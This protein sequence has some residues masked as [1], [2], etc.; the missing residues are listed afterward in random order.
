MANSRTAAC[1]E[2]P[3]SVHTKRFL[4]TATA[5]PGNAEQIAKSLIMGRGRIRDYGPAAKFDHQLVI[6]LEGD[7]TFR[8]EVD[9]FPASWTYQR[10]R[11]GRKNGWEK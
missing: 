3:R 2:A 8:A 5:F 11:A 10:R 4:R 1:D 6:L 9:L 7:I